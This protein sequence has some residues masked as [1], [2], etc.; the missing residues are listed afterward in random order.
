MSKDLAK[1]RN[2]GCGKFDGHPAVDKCREAKRKG[3]RKNKN[4]YSQARREARTRGSQLFEE[5]LH[6][7]STSIL[8]CIGSWTSMHTAYT[9]LMFFRRGWEIEGKRNDEIEEEIRQ[10][11][12]RQHKMIAND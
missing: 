6:Q 2:K 1:R 7:T 5:C 9:I 3:Y 8:P 4:E 10:N 12:T 11:M